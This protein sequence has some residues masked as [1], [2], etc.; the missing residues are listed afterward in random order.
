MLIC[1]LILQGLYLQESFITFNSLAFNMP[2]YTSNP[3]FDDFI[4]FSFV[5]PGT[6]AMEI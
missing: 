2:A 1:S 5:T 4:N 6:L 3:D